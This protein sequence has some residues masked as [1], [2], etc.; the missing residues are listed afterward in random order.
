MLKINLLSGKKNKN[1]NSC[2]AGKV[3]YMLRLENKIG[4]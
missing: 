3:I 1:K 4:N 2:I